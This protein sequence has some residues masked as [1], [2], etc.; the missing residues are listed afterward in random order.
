MDPLTVMLAAKKGYEIVKGTAELVGKGIELAKTGMQAL[1]SALGSEKPPVE[2]AIKA[3]GERNRNEK[4]EE[5]KKDPIAVARNADPK[6]LK[7][8]IKDT[9]KYLSEKGQIK[10]SEGDAALYSNRSKYA[11]KPP[12]S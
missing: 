12:G 2:K 6:V 7:K 11:P 4:D 1:C 8:S 3:A 10:R 9:Q 5:N